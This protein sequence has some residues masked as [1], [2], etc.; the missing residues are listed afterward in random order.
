MANRLANAHMLSFNIATWSGTAWTWGVQ[1]L[2]YETTPST[3]IEDPV[4]F[5][6]DPVASVAVICYGITGTQSFGV[7]TLSSAGVKT[8][9]DTPSLAITERDWGTISV[10]VTTGDYYIFLMN[11]NTDG[12][13]GTLGYI[14]H[15]AG[16]SWDSAM[17]IMDS[18]TS[19]EGLNMRPTGT[20]P[21]LDLIYAQGSSAPATVRFTRLSPFNPPSFSIV[22]SPTIVTLQAGSTGTNT[23]TLT[24]LYSFTGVVTL[25]TSVS[26]S[27]ASASPSPATVSLTS[28]GDNAPVP[29]ICTSRIGDNTL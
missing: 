13:S 20:S 4:T 15:P 12:G 28:G 3:G 29:A 26:P 2:T 19:N 25:S 14:R 22:A 23:L 7:F 8:H 17:T 11:V 10:H 6:W 1:N 5:A 24:S 18:A 21:T 9:L 16:G 27:G